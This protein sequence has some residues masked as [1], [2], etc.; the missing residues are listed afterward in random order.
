MHREL[1]DNM[2]NNF[3]ATSTTHVKT[4]ATVTKAVWHTRDR[5]RQTRNTINM[6]SLPQSLAKRK[7]PGYVRIPTI[8]RK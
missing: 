5:I 3:L 6:S 8:F 1:R 4:L 7:T 2:A